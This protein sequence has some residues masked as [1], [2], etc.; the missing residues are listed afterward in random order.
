VK[1]LLFLFCALGFPLVCGGGIVDF[2]CGGPVCGD[3]TGDNAVGEH[4]KE[5]VMGFYGGAATSEGSPDTSCLDGVFTADGYAD[6]N[7]VLAWDWRL[8][9]PDALNLCDGPH[10]Q[11]FMSTPGGGGS[12]SFDP[13]AGRGFGNSLLIAGKKNDASGYFSPD[14]DLFIYDK[15]V[16][17][18]GSPFSPAV[19]RSN[20][21]VFCDLNGKIYQVNTRYGVIRLN[22]GKVVVT[23]GRIS[24]A[25]DPR[26]GEAA[27][28]SFGVQKYTSQGETE[29]GGRPILDAEIDSDGYLYVVPV[30]ISPS[31]NPTVNSYLAAAK[32][33]ID[34]AGTPC[35]SIVQLY[36]NEQAGTQDPQRLGLHEIELDPSGNVYVI[37]GYREN[38]SNFLWA[39]LNSGGTPTRIALDNVSGVEG[40]IPDPVGLFASKQ[41]P[42]V[43]LASGQNSPEA[44]SVKVYGLSTTNFSLTLSRTIQIN[45]MGHVTGM[46]EDPA[47]GD[48]WVTGFKMENI[49]ETLDLET[50]PFYHPYLAKFPTSSNDP[51]TATHLNTSGLALPVSVAWMPS[52]LISSDPTN[53]STLWRSQKNIAR[54]IFDGDITTPP[55]GSV[56]IQELLAGGSYGSNI[57]SNF[58]FT[59]ENDTNSK[60]RI[61]KIYEAT[62]S[63]V[64]QKWFAVRNIG[65]WTGV[66]KFIVHYQVQRGDADNN[67]AVTDTDVI[68][69]EDATGIFNC[70]DNDRRDMNGDRNIL[71]SDMSVVNN[72]LPS[73]SVPKPSGH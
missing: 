59:V 41:N 4:D 10:Y 6:V 23:P 60:P 7:D 5:S 48:I 56:L 46:A 70:P 36:G 19:S 71:H 73:N 63:L 34:V 40:G 39:Y 72:Y 51:V 43:Y 37:G 49:P 9:D 32:L 3:V 69:V 55:A 26:Y 20:G 45:G 47:N 62:T 13:S 30:V 65:S 42:V 24:I 29:F 28:V 2:Y 50:A 11:Y 67:G 21:R 8:D 35:Y 54:L 27:I 58:T 22:D 17:Y 38:S 18:L 52:C 16:S 15:Q 12:Q 57:S 1:A 33:Q 68:I 44:T 66:A 31:S 14:E 64:N 53:N 61:L 25:S